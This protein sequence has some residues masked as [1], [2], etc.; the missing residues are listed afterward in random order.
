MLFGKSSRISPRTKPLLVIIYMCMF[1]AVDR[2][3]N[4][5]WGDE[6]NFERKRCFGSVVVDVVFRANVGHREK[7]VDL[8]PRNQSCPWVGFFQ[9]FALFHFI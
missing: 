9:V 8:L 6:S 2:S 5:K 3:D 1:C 4:M 7:A